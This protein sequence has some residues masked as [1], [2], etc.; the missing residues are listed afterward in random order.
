MKRVIACIT[1][2]PCLH[3]TADAAAWIAQQT[4]RQ[5]ILLQVLDDYAA[6]YHLGEFS[7]VIGFESN[8]MLLEELANI[9]KQQKQLA[10]QYGEQL[11][12]HIQQYIQSKFS[13]QAFRI[14]REGDFLEQTLA[15]LEEGDITVIGKVGERSSELNRPCGSNVERFIRATTSSV[16]VVGTHFVIPDAFLFAYHPSETCQTM[17][18]K[19]GQSELLKDLCCHLVY[20]GNEANV[21]TEATAYLQFSGLQVKSDSLYGPVAECLIDYYKQHQLGLMVMGAFAHSKLQQFFLG[22]TTL[23]VF[24]ATDLPLLVVR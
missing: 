10:Q 23:Q 13:I 11:L 12:D 19:I 8:A 6:P 4:G 16:L 14:Q 20:V 15:E 24:K 2:S 1:A 3:A 5:L 9:N 21:L 18:R 17:L 22:S 7:G